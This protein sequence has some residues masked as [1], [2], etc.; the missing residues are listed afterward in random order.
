MFFNQKDKRSQSGNLK[1]KCS[2]LNRGA[3]DRKMLQLFSFSKVKNTLNFMSLVLWQIKMIGNKSNESKLHSWRI[4]TANWIRGNACYPSSYLSV[5]NRLS[6]LLLSKNIKTNKY[7]TKISSIVLTRVKLGLSP[8]KRKTG[9]GCPG[10]RCS[11]VYL[12]LRE[13]TRGGGRKWLRPL[14]KLY[15]L[16]AVS[17]TLSGW[18]S[19]RFMLKWEGNTTAPVSLESR[20]ALA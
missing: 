20:Q 9:G 1:K 8:W 11:E 2:L 17:Q 15:N 5:L 6:S 4:L 19:Q 13:E 16:H 14:G 12:E 7:R 10:T 18:L 3:L